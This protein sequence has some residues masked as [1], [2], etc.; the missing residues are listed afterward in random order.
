V[1]ARLLLL[2]SCLT[3]PA[4]AQYTLHACLTSTKE[5]FV[6]AKLAPSGLF[7]KTAG[8]EWQHAGYNHPF[9]TGLDYDADPSVVYLAAGNALIRTSDHGR[10]WKFLT[11]SDVTELLDV[12]VDRNTPG[13]IYFAWCHGIRVSRDG[14][15]H[16]AELSGGLHRKYTQAIRVDRQKSG[17]LVA[18]GEE[19]VFRSED[20]GKT[21]R[22]AGAAGFQVTRIE[23]SPHEACD[24]LA[25]TQKGG[26][27]RSTDCGRTF[28][29]PGRLGVGSNLYD[30]AY[31]PTDPKRIAVAGWGVGV[32][33]TED[34]GK[35]WQTRNSGFSRTEVVSVVF[36]PVNRGRMYASV[37]E[38]ALYVSNDAGKGWLKEGLEGSVVNRLKFVPDRGE[39]R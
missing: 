33:V 35:T 31:D 36:D 9:L 2:L 27:F 3:F 13:T 23:Q 16:W 24:W 26:L 30:V 10:N 19:G 25:A 38:D 7:L 18:G 22:A 34:G 37:N 11:G 32:V 28:E 14:G 15:A 39:V 21:W 8:G 12:A 5:Y 17:V 1:T 6:G 20:G 4:A 29:N